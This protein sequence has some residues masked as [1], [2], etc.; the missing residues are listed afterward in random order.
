MSEP[1]RKFWLVRPKE[2]AGLV[3]L[4]QLG[5]KGETEYSTVFLD[6]RGYPVSLK[7]WQEYE[8]DPL[9]VTCKSCQRVLE[10]YGGYGGCFS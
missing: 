4:R 8:G 6:C 10:W 9:T 3:H 2:G 5:V 1:Y 7:K